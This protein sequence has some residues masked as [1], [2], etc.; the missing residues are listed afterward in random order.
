MPTA[1]EALSITPRVAPARESTR[2]A[3]RSCAKSVLG[4][5]GRPRTRAASSSAWRSPVHWITGPESYSGAAAKPAQ[6]LV[7]R[8]TSDLPPGIAESFAPHHPPRPP[9]DVIKAE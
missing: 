7:T 4:T 9:Q 8:Q 1:S 2:L 6:L 5:D 3:C